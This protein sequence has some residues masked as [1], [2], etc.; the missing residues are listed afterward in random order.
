MREVKFRGQEK[1]TGQWVYGYLLKESDTTYCF[2][3]DYERHP[4]VDHYYICFDRMTDWCLPNEHRKVEVYPFTV[5]EWTGLRD[6]DGKEIFEGDIVKKRIYNG[7][8]K[9]CIVSFSHGTFNCG[10]GYG[11]STPTHPYTLDDSNIKVV[12]NMYDNHELLYE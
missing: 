1:K 3:E 6:K 4:E 10:Y 9:L 8:I 7:T 5:G 11:S 12:G 2:T